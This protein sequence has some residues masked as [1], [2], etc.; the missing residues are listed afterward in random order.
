MLFKDLQKNTPFF[1]VNNCNDEFKVYPATILSVS[2]PRF[3]NIT[4]QFSNK[5]IDLNVNF[6]NKNIT[7]T[8][9]ENAENMVF[10]PNGTILI[11]DQQNLI[12]QLKSLKLGCENTIKEGEAAKSK[13][14]FVE[15]SL[16]EYDISFK[17]KKEYEDKL[18]SMSQQ[19]EEMSKKM[20]LLFE[21]FNS[22]NK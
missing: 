19:M 8:V 18:L 11:L 1:I 6:D 13:L 20:S 15:K 10:A 17:E 16:E 12:S 5:V 2:Q 4:N 21:K 14:A 3:E 9:L 22:N 7:Y